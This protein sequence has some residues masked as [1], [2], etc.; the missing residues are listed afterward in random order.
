MGMLLHDCI[1]SHVLLPANRREELH[2]AIGIGI[3]KH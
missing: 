2:W 1:L 3:D